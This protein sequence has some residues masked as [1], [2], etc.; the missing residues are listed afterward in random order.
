MKVSI[1]T[2]KTCLLYVLMVIYNSMISLSVIKTSNIFK[3][4]FSWYSDL[5][6][7]IALKI[8]ITKQERSDYWSKYNCNWRWYKGNKP[9]SFFF[10][11]SFAWWW[12][13]RTASNAKQGRLSSTRLLT[14]ITDGFCSPTEADVM[15]WQARSTLSPG[16][17]HCLRQLSLT[18]LCDMSLSCDCKATRIVS[19]I[20]YSTTLERDNHE[21]KNL[22]G[23]LWHLHL[24]IL[25]F[26]NKM[27]FIN[28]SKYW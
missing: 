22:E 26:L 14:S 11:L 24:F 8:T 18:T 3:P 6:S 28:H 25:A 23:I 20:S 27:K 17:L 1:W 9:A 2:I 10:L 19:V 4:P 5:L 16:V 21:I 13:R 15:D 12:N 7:N